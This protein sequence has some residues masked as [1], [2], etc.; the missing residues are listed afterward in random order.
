MSAGKRR[1][2]SSV[3]SDRGKSVSVRSPVVDQIGLDA[4]QRTRA[5]GRDPWASSWNDR[6]RSRNSKVNSFDEYWRTQRRMARE[7]DTSTRP[8]NQAQGNRGGVWSEESESVPRRLTSW[9]Q[10]GP[11]SLRANKRDTVDTVPPLP[12]FQ[13]TAGEHA[14]QKPALPQPR[15]S[16][17]PTPLRPPPVRLSPPRHSPTQSSSPHRHRSELSGSYVQ[18]PTLAAPRTPEQPVSRPS[19]SSGFSWQ[20]KSPRRGETLG[21]D[22]AAKRGMTSGGRRS[23]DSWE[24][25]EDEDSP[26]IPLPLFSPRSLTGK[27]QTS[28]PGTPV[29]ATSRGATSPRDINGMIPISLSKSAGQDRSP[30]RN[31]KQI[32][33]SNPRPPSGYTESVYE[34]EWAPSSDDESTRGFNLN[35]SAGSRRSRPSRSGRPKASPPPPGNWI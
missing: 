15:Q 29:K 11:G 5:G 35:K 26:V 34:T 13:Q 8:E 32:G 19:P 9:F 16:T 24:M 27:T 22:A 14:M 10:A 28:G 2:K 23:V 30:G 17:Q 21:L 3:I 25:S 33:G 1:E 31:S 12:R 20:Q 4:M 6:Q 18:T 7:T